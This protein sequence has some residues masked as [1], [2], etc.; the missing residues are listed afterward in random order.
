MARAGG[1]EDPVDD[2]AQP[3]LEPADAIEPES[4]LVSGRKLAVAIL[5][6]CGLVLLVV[7]LIYAQVAKPEVED[8]A[9]SP[10][11]VPLIRAPAGPLKVRPQEAGGMVVEG[12]NATVYAA[13]DGVDPAGRIALEALPEEPIGRPRLS[14]DAEAGD[15]AI[16]VQTPPPFAPKP[17][18]KPAE[19]PKPTTTGSV[20]ARATKPDIPRPADSAP[21]EPGDT[22]PR[23]GRM[24]Q[25]GAFSSEAKAKA[26]WKDFAARYS[27]LSGL[28]MSVAPLARDGKTLYRLR[29]TGLTS[30]KQANDLCGRLKVAGEQCGVTD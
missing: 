21:T 3:W 27:Y 11:D 10:G 23:A 15:A 16:V 28:T 22:T 14:E 20:P 19:T 26:A 2:E 5:A 6:L 29:A 8:A 18:P 24:L 1:A 25:L 9:V 4:T 12:E 17:T 30:V 13:A 7:G